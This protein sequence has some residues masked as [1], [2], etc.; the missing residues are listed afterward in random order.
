MLFG[1]GCPLFLPFLS[2]TSLCTVCGERYFD[3]EFMKNL[4]KIINDLR[5]LTTEMSI[6]NYNEKVA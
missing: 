1:I 3:D 4:E 5:T 6:V 2:V